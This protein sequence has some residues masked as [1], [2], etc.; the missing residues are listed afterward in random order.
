M[1]GDT[2][3]THSP[4]DTGDHIGHDKMTGKKLGSH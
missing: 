3:H 2:E 4:Q 1:G